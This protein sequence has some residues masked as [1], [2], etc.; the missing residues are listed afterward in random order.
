MMHKPLSRSCGY[1][2]CLQASI[3]EPCYGFADEYKT[4]IS[5]EYPCDEEA[6]TSIVH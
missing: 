6:S 1:G 4:C 5:P 3:P 2:I